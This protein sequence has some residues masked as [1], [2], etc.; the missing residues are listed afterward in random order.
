[1]GG[2]APRPWD[3]LGAPSAGFASHIRVPSSVA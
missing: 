2:G 3:V 1:M